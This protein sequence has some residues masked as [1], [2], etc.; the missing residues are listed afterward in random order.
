MH[1]ASARVKRL[2]GWCGMIVVMAVIIMGMGAAAILDRD[3]I[4][5]AEMHAPLCHCLRRQ[6]PH[7]ICMAAQ[8]G[9]FHTMMVVKAR[10]HG[11]NGNVVIVVM[12]AV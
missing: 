5:L 6:A 4:D 9:H 2:E 12:G 8:Q 11:G 10:A 3:Q 1:G 7:G